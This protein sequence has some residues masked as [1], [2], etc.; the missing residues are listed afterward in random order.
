MKA[1]E[2]GHRL[3][4]FKARPW[5]GSRLWNEENRKPRGRE[6]G[7]EP[8]EGCLCVLSITCKSFF[9]LKFGWTEKSLKDCLCSFKYGNNGSLLPVLGRQFTFKLVWGPTSQ[10]L[11]SLTGGEKQVLLLA[12]ADSGF[13]FISKVSSGL[14][15]IPF[16]TKPDGHS[17]CPGKTF[18]AVGFNEG[19]SS[20]P[21]LAYADA[22]GLH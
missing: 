11:A 21:K 4:R 8:E 18:L 22:L 10:G 16:L 15:I 14:G 17:Q 2:E 1:K 13:Y 6:T 5:D 19:T 3:K 7:R 20:H 12:Q 9:S